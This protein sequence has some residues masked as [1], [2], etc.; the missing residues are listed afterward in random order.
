MSH[1]SSTLRTPYVSPS[2]H[3]FGDL[4]EVTAPLTGGFS[5][6]PQGTAQGSG[7]TPAGDPSCFSH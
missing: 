2:L 1:V 4:V 3:D 5:D 7:S 6:I